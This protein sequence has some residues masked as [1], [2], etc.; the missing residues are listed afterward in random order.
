M[1]IWV[2]GQNCS[3]TSSREPSTLLNSH[4]H[5]RGKCPLIVLLFRDPCPPLSV[6]PSPSFIRAEDVTLKRVR[7]FHQAKAKPGTEPPEWANPLGTTASSCLPCRHLPRDREQEQK[8]REVGNNLRQE[9]TGSSS[10][11]EVPALTGEVMS[12]AEFH[13]R[14][15]RGFL[16]VVRVAGCK[17]ERSLY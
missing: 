4:Q 9:R 13:L 17:G 14:A 3:L 8:D 10:A 12:L 2:G 5:H 7:C 16:G 15:A 1:C 6:S 11:W